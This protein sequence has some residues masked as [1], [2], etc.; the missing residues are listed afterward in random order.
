MREQVVAIA[1]RYPDKSPR[2]LAWFTTDTKGTFI[3]ESS[4]YRI[5][6]RFDL[7]T[8]P[9][10]QLVSANDRLKNPTTRVNEPWQADFRQ[11]KVLGSGWYYL[12]TVLDDFSRY[13]LAWRLSSTMVTTDV[14]ATLD[15]AF[16]RTGVS[17]VKVEH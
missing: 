1:L 13:I 7:V 2:Q 9:V 5:L 8:S 4:F 14:Q 16:E 15:D 17:Q 10:F 6:K 3:S 11:F 12:C